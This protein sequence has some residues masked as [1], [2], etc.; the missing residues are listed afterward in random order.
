MDICRGS[1]VYSR[2]G[3]DKGG[4]FLVLSADEDNVYLADGVTRRVSKPKKK[5]RKHINKTN[6]V[7]ELDFENISD[8]AVRKALASIKTD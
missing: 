3:R 4:L 8:S 6:T 2:A 7:L 1:L 5:K